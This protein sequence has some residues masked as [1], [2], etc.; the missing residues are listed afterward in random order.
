MNDALPTAEVFHQFAG[1][2]LASLGFQLAG[3]PTVTLGNYQDA[4]ALYCCTRGFFVSVG[5]SP[6]D[7]R[8]AAVSFGRKWSW[9]GGARGLSNYLFVFARK[10]WLELPQSY[11]LVKGATGVRAANQCILEDLQ[12]TVP[13]ILSRLTLADLEAIELEQFGMAWSSKNQYGEDYLAH[14]TMSDVRW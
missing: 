7:A 14:V 10:Y 12:R 2:K 1:G 6:M 11:P 5:F 13:Q 4:A 8:A 9:D 3:D